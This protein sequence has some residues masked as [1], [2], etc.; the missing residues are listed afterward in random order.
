MGG[1]KDYSSGHGSFI[2]VKEHPEEELIFVIGEGG[3]G[4]DI[5]VDQWPKKDNSELASVYGWLNPKPQEGDKLHVPMKSG[6]TL[7][8]EFVK[9]RPCGDPAD[10]FFADVKPLGYMKD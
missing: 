7:L 4:N 9:V 1:I 5:V 6:K 10:M 2:P 8:C 3:W